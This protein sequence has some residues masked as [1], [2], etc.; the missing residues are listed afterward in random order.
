MMP[1]VGLHNNNTPGIFLRPFIPGCSS[2]LSKQWL[3]CW[4]GHRG[5]PKW[6]WQWFVRR[7]SGPICSLSTGDTGLASRS[8]PPPTPPP[9]SSPFLNTQRE[10]NENRERVHRASPGSLHVWALALTS[11]VPLDLPYRLTW[12]YV[13]TATKCSSNTD[14]IRLSAILLGARKPIWLTTKRIK[15]NNQQCNVTR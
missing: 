12:S 13:T 2:C 8:P 4:N 14:V 6:L 5:R 9:P 10:D 1:T 7:E 11:L 15:F 3:S